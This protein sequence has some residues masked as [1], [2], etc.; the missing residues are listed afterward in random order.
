MRRRPR[1]NNTVTD[2][3]KS[4]SMREIR[5]AHALLEDTFNVLDARLAELS[6]RL[7]DTGKWLDIHANSLRDEYVSYFKA[8]EMNSRGRFRIIMDETRTSESDY[9]VLTDFS[10]SRADR[11]LMPVLFRD[12]IRDLVSNARK[13]TPPGGTIRFVLHQLDDRLQL[14]V[15]DT[16]IGIPEDELHLVFEYGYRATNT[17]NIRTLGAVS[18]LQKRC[19]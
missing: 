9:L 6:L 3:G 7:P 5:E 14:S 12:V 15:S 18:V 4:S 2:T 11:F 17:E 1:G 10:S 19:T 16:G 8:Q 13:Y